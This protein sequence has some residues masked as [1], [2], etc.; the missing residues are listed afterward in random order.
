MAFEVIHHANQL[1]SVSQLRHKSGSDIHATYAHY[2]SGQFADARREGGLPVVIPVRDEAHDLPATLLSLAQSREAVPIVVDNGSVDD[3]VQRATDM[4]AIVLTA[5]SGSRK[6]G[7]TQTGMRFA[8][9]E[10]HAHAAAATDGDTLAPA[11]WPAAMRSRMQ[12]EEEGQGV[13]LF[14]T[15]ISW[16]GTSAL[17]DAS[18]TVLRAARN[19]RRLAKGLPVGAH[20]YDY[21][22]SFGDAGQV[23]DALDTLDPALFVGDDCQ[24][25][26]TFN[27]AGI[28][29]VGA[30]G[31]RTA[32]V[33]RGDRMGSFRD[34]WANRP[35]SGVART[36]S[37][38]QQY[39]VENTAPKSLNNV[40]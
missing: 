27:Q 22:L 2:T 10:L 36:A 20:G 16:H 5:P 18:R 3:T 25:R 33:S 34:I 30:V 26:D 38:E 19:V 21:G 1:V 12:H 31:L 14:A 32:V 15:G 35:S 6:V 11:Y 40:E 7:A 13:A 24:M 9:E 37:Y 39:G 17:V 8:A 23:L 29:V 28:K 4:G